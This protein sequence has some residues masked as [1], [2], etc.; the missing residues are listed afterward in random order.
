MLDFEAKKETILACFTHTQQDVCKL[1]N[2]ASSLKQN[3][4]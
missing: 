2:A 3:K 4:S 1:K